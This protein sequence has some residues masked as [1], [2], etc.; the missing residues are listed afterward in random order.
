MVYSVD[1]YNRSKSIFI[2]DGTVDDTLDVRLIGKSYTGYG[3]IQNENFV[4]L[5]EN[6]AGI[7]PPL[8]P[9]NGQLWY[10]TSIRKIKLFDAVLQKWKTIGTSDTSP[11]PPLGLSTGDLWWD[12]TNK[13]LYVFDGK[14]YT[15]IGPQGTPG[16]GTTEMQ[17][18]TLTDVDGKAHS[19][20]I[21]FVD[22]TA[23]FIISDQEFVPNRASQK[24]IGESVAF[25][26]IKKGITLSNVNSSGIVTSG[27]PDIYWGTSS[28]SIGLVSDDPFY[29][30]YTAKDFLLKHNVNFLDVVRFHDAGFL[31]GDS[32]DLEVK[33]D[34]NGITPIFN[35]RTSDSMKFQTLNGKHTPLTLDGT[36]ILPGLDNATDIGATN[37]SF[38]NVYAKS[39]NGKLIG[40]GST[41]TNVSANN[42]SGGV[43]SADVLSGKYN[44]DISGNS[45]SATLAVKSNLLF[46][47][48]VA[49]ADR[50]R[51]GRV[52]APNVGTPN[53]VA[54][55]D[56]SGSL[57]AVM[58]QGTATSAL[59][60]DLAEKYLADDI[61][62][63]GTVVVIGGEAEVTACKLGDRAFGAVS[64]APAFMMNS[65]LE[66]GTYIA[67]KGRVPVKVIGPV[68]KG[69]RLVAA[70]DGCAIVANAV[71]KNMPISARGFPDTFAIALESSNEV[72]V[73][74]VES[75]IL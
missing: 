54:V 43:I 26:V 12:D 39:F 17:T 50:Y 46:V 14:T 37:L 3:E 58:F 18:R 57:N 52:D 56:V 65:G 10:D 20:I 60:A 68:K 29:P 28:S 40:D 22:D 5:L 23:A 9:I 41:I 72:G 67:L 16:L 71:L 33:I 44:I 51:P 24:Y 32:D 8:K 42:I 53:T 13:Q 49:A 36:D 31:L 62:E 73:K 4:Y 15:L 19:V 69:D 66:G 2:E 25:P 61:Y 74:L 70:D 1:N 55:R 27:L 35:V 48:D 11:T 45:E 21:A 47:Q 7:N 63:T 59:Y 38:R 6:F 64:A 30:L 34:I 75:V